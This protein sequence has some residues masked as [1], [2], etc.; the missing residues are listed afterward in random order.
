MD[1][2]RFFD[3]LTRL[4]ECRVARG[5]MRF[6]LHAARSVSGSALTFGAEG[7]GWNFAEARASIWEKVFARSGAKV[8]I[9]AS[10]SRIPLVFEFQA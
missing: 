8:S 4:I 6:S 2:D 10:E 9:P 3:A 7:S 5:A 1:S